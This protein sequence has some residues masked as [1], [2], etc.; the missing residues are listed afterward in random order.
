MWGVR[1]VVAW[2]WSEKHVVSLVM[3]NPK[4]FRVCTTTETR[5]PAAAVDD[6]IA[7]AAQFAGIV[8]SLDNVALR[9][10]AIVMCLA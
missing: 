9:R 1:F 7:I 8:N 10:M 2:H 5:Y 6:R 3:I 4:V